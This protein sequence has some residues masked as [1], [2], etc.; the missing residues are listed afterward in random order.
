MPARIKLRRRRRTKIIATLGPASSTAEVLARLF[1]GG[2][3]VFR[4]NFSHG[5][6][7]DHAMRVR[8]IREIEDKFDR[9]IGNFQALAHPMADLQTEIDAARL[10]A[11][12]AAWMISAGQTS[13]STR[14]RSS[15]A[16]RVA[17]DLPPPT[18]IHTAQ[19]SCSRICGI[20]CS[21]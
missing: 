17:T 7:E 9:P 1:Q 16:V 12:R 8:L 10:L 19:R 18:S 14:D 20:A 4:L 13:S 11:Y 21:S 2:A 6:H 5:T 15:S 3:D